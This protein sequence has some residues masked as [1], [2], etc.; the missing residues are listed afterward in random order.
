MTREEFKN[1]VS[2]RIIFSDGATGTELI[3]RGMPQGFGS[4]ST[5]KLYLKFS[6]L[7]FGL[8]AI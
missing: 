1:A 5:R 7:I 4:L 2:R 3:K 6:R 8:A